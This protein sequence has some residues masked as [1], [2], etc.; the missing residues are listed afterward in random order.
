MAKDIA[1][2]EYGGGLL[3]KGDLPPSVNWEEYQRVAA[4]E[5]TSSKALRP[6]VSLVHLDGRA[7][8]ARVFLQPQ[9]LTLKKINSPPQQAENVVDEFFDEWRKAGETHRLHAFYHLFRKYAWSLPATYGD[10][11]VSLFEQWKAV[12][13]LIF[14]SGNG[15]QNAPAEQFTLIGGD[16][17]GIQD[18][19]YTITSKGAAKGLRGRSFFL[20]LLGEAVIERLL[21]ELN[22]CQANVIYAAGGNF[23]LL[24]P[25]LQTSINGRRVAEIL[26]KAY[27]EMEQ[28]LLDEFQG[29]LALALAWVPLSREDIGTHVFA[30]QASRKVKELIAE[31]KRS[32][33]STTVGARWNVLFAPQGK[34][35]NRYCAVCQ[36][37]LGKGE[38][39]KLA[40]EESFICPVCES[41]GKLA[42][43]LGEAH[44]LSIGTKKPDRTE[45]WQDA[46]HS[47]G[48]VWFSF[49][50]S[51]E[52]VYTLNDT[53]FLSK[54]AQGFRFIA[55]VTPHVIQEDVKRWEERQEESEEKPE[56][57]DVRT[58]GQM[59]ADAKGM[60]GLGVLRMDVDNL[61]QVMIGG[62]K[63][64]NMAA[65]SALSAAL[66][67]F[68]AGYLNILCEEVQGEH[69]RPESLY[70]I[71][72]GGDDLFIVGAWDLMPILAERIQTEFSRYTGNNPSLTISGAVTIEGEKFPLYQAAE[73]AGD[74]E[75]K[76]KAYLR[77]SAGM[78][79]NAFHFLGLEVSWEEWGQVTLYRQDIETALAGEKGA[80][81]ALLQILQ[82][83]YAQ[84]EYQ[85]KN[86]GKTELGPWI[87]RGAYALSRLSGRIPKENEAAREAV[88]RLA[89][90]C[91]HPKNIRFAALAARWTELLTRKEE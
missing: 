49:D 8:P 23:M 73:R 13:A 66:D 71:Y 87:W 61:G 74:A 53:D 55:N 91:L 9:K 15:W 89:Q 38:G 52:V 25:S 35:G 29:D 56:V 82:N 85:K 27:A 83:I 22:L 59:A 2:I 58:F 50:K 34:R 36:M 46:L 51:G 80:S 33:F 54:G 41:F 84:Y 3:A 42:R 63:E 72:S 43:S 67:M 69:G 68:F 57:G 48:G 37:P 4:G 62:L 24:A 81:R 70:V 60:P 10:E 45:R 44:F 16:I 65:T 90:S 76:A 12:T 28:A 20:Q 78:E 79:K 47:I 88:A 5:K 7:E 30:D 26:E 18:F 17:P 32:R 64:R 6:I 86:N 75:E 40:G 77:N 19:V 14:A 21:R 31:R 1:T 11:G 39:Q